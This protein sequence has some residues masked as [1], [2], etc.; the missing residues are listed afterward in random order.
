MVVPAEPG[1]TFWHDE[2]FF[3]GYSG[4]LFLCKLSGEILAS[5]CLVRRVLHLDGLGDGHEEHD[6]AENHEEHVKDHVELVAAVVTTTAA[7][8]N[9][10]HLHDEAED[11]EQ[12]QG[13]VDTELRHDVAGHINSLE[14]HG[15]RVSLDRGSHWQV[16]ILV[17][18]AALSI[19]RAKIRVAQIK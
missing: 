8:D 5:A 19:V 10:R 15:G 11:Y 2:H 7:S 18:P 17:A 6:D 1:S 13:D 12:D 3:I 4:L 16:E 9:V 14:I